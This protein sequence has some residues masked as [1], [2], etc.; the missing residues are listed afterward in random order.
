M[1]RGYTKEFLVDAFVSRY[2]VLGDEIVAKQRNL[3]EQLWE[4]VS[5]EEFRQYCSL[6][7]EAIR[8]YKQIML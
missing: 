2:A 4:R 8:L 3:A 5:K 7:A 6:D 1:A